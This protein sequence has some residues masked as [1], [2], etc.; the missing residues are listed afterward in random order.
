MRNDHGFTLIEVLASILILTILAT[1]FFQ[2]FIFS[3]KT[4]TSNQDKLVALN[5]AQGVLERIKHGSYSEITNISPET[6]VAY[7][8]TYNLSDCASYDEPEKSACEKRYKIKVNDIDYSIAI[9]VGEKVET[10]LSVYPVEVKV[11]GDDGKLKSKVKGFV[12]I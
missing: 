5:V 6:Q 1:V 3:Q 7:P 12:E 9:I 4:T 8:K 11:N 2:M 10:G